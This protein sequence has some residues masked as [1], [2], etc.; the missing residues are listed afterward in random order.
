MIHTL[1]EIELE[2]DYEEVL[3]DILTLLNGVLPYMADNVAIQSNTLS[4]QK[5]D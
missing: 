2:C 3:E 5:E 1:I 4:L